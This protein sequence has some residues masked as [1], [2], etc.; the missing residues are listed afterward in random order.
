LNRVLSLAKGT[1]L[2]HIILLGQI[3]SENKKHAQDAGIELLTFEELE[4]RGKNENYEA[5]Q[6]GMI[7]ERNNL[8]LITLY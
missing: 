2:K 7:I 5:V 6:V 1:T 8:L 4:N 3:T